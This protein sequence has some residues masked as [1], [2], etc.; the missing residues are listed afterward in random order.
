MIRLSSFGKLIFTSL[1]V[2]SIAACSDSSTEI[3][4]PGSQGPNP[5]VNQQP[6][7]DPA[8]APDPVA[9]N[10]PA[11]TS[12]ITVGSATHC[13]LEGVIT[14]N[15]TLV[16]GN[17]YTL[18]GKVTVGVN[19]DS[20]GAGGTRAILTIQPGVTVY[21]QNVTS[22]LVV[23]RGSRLEANGT[24]ASPITFTSA[25]DMQVAASFNQTQRA[26]YTGL[27][28][29]DPNTSEW[30]GIVING[31]ATINT[32]NQVGT[33]EAEGEGDSG[34]YG[35]TN[36]ADNSGT[37]SYVLV[38]YAGN[39]ITATDEL[40][41][42]AFQ[43]VGSGT[44]IDY[45]HVHNGADDGVEFFGGTVNAKH[46][47]ITGADDDS[48][49]WTHGWR[50]NVQY[51]IVI[52]NDNQPN[53]DR[54]IEADNLEGNNDF[55]PRSGPSIANSTFIGGTTVGDTGIV[56]RRGTT[57]KLYNFVVTN[58]RDACYDLDS[59]ATFTA[60]GSSAT[61]ITGDTV[62]QSSI[63]GCNDPT[64]DE[65]GD[66]WDLATFVTNQPNNV[67][68]N[69]TLAGVVNGANEAAVSA[70]DVSTIDAFFDSVDYIG[71]VKDTA[72]NW[73]TGWSFGINGEASCPAG[74]TPQGTTQCIMSG[75]YNDDIR[76][77]GPFDYIL[78]GRV[79]VGT[80]SGPDPDAPLATANPA[81][82]TIDP[83]VKVLGQNTTSYLV[84]TRGSQLRSNGT[85]SAPV[86]FSSVNDST[87]NLDTDTSL[88][89]GLVINGRA[90]LNT[91]NQVNPPCEASG[92]G[93]SGLY[94]GTSN[95][96][97]SGS[98]IYTVVKYA[99]NP[100]TA[101]D[102]LNGIAFQG[103]GSG[104][105]IDYLQV[106]NGADDGIEFFGGTV[107][108]KHLVVT[109]ADDDSI[110]WTHG[111]TGKIQHVVVY[112]N[113][114]QAN[115][116]RGIEAD[117]LEGNNDF[118]PRSGPTIVNATLVGGTSV[119]DTGVVLRRGTT[120]K[121]YNFVMTNWRDAC[122]DLD[123][124]A[125]FTAAGT[126]AVAL[127]GDTVVQSSLLDCSD[128][129][130]DETGD[131]WNLRAFI[132]NQSNNF[133]SGPPPTGRSSSLV[134]PT[135]G[136]R[137]FISGVNEGTVTAFDASTLDPF[138]DSTDY[139]GGVKDAVNNWTSGWTVWLNQ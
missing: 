134:A 93:D 43:G 69:T 17:T 65:T 35:G 116:D 138:F 12:E 133:T 7:P 105:T 62:V 81:I 124:T 137:S 84:V 15:T 123:S 54:G 32:C 125:T 127:T 60:A 61:N 39:P 139:I 31:L 21:G 117:N 6:A 27:A 9:G 10:C 20:S 122:Y 28:Q 64:D 51:L 113:D 75:V 24:Q 103:V 23:S 45:L 104:T 41:G 67:F 36:D 119:G 135:G 57:A 68:R 56:L 52:Q 110:D 29:N 91:C 55:L 19:T 63:F 38:K 89:G 42:I 48:L 86:I 49:D 73:T 97:N 25:Q 14:S 83:G 79:D 34:L 80:D 26:A 5:G 37:L 108:V 78:N 102:E 96:D 4:S 66:P 130:D 58:F 82:M 74:T 50:G 111:Y 106:H 13:E 114:N 59:T 107:N 46:V 77:V 100:I 2:F 72:G 33:C 40:N 101:T 18:K 129:T 109:G 115:S 44:T 1:L 120:G 71:A 98:L 95:T 11:G 22:Y 118:L 76:L 53:S 87:A 16:A 126:S 47:I 128:P 131:P 94:G 88:W 3:T 92:E 121:L 70:T 132:E 136:T 90:I 8:P 112:Q 99:G 30:G 85:Q